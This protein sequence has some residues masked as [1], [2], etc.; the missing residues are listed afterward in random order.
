MVDRWLIDFQGVAQY[1]L[2]Q[3]M[4]ESAIMTGHK[5]TGIR[6]YS[7]L[8]DWMDCIAFVPDDRVEEAHKVIAKAIS[9]FW[10]DKSLECY[11]DCIEYALKAA[12]IMH[13]SVYEA[14]DATINRDPD[15]W[16][17]EKWLELIQCPVVNLNQRQWQSQLPD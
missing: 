1:N 15:W 6:W 7:T 3:M 2:R 17:W 10:E 9:D 5:M 12:D 8:N 11:G 16:N 13:V 14:W 4:K